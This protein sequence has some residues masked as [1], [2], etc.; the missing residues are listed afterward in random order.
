MAPINFPNDH[1]FHA[2]E[3][4]KG[5][6]IP[7]HYIWLTRPMGESFARQS[8]HSSISTRIL[9]EALKK[10]SRKFCQAGALVPLVL[11]DP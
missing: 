1:R 7:C 9:E 3:F 5:N 2:R 6:Q 10:R 11:E 8:T 4:V